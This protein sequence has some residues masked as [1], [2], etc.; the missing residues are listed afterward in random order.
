M[1]Y[2][3]DLSPKT[4]QIYKS[5]SCDLDFLICNWGTFEVLPVRQG[6]PNLNTSVGQ[7]PFWVKYSLAQVIP[8]FLKS[9][10]SATDNY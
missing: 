3:S 5:F 9:G 1:F 8:Y 10:Y 6:T 2:D 4:Q 7:D